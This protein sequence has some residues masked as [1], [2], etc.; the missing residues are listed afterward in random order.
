MP[1]HERRWRRNSEPSRSVWVQEALS[2]GPR[3][4]WQRC[5]GAAGRTRSQESGVRSQN[6][7]RNSRLVLHAMQLVGFGN[8]PIST[9]TYEAKVTTRGQ[10]SELRNRNGESVRPYACATRV[11]PF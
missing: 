7:D 8:N 1:K 3:M 5:Y 2:A 10:E 9:G 4:R 11:V 6:K